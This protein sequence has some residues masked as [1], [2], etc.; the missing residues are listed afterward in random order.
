VT[1]AAPLKA[2]RPRLD[3]AAVVTAAAD[4]L[5]ESG[6]DSFSM[7][8][9]GERL[10]VTAMALYRHVADRDD[11]EQALVEQV[12]SDFRG[13]SQP[14]ADWQD[15]LAD[16]MNSLRQCWLAHP[17]VGALLGNRQEIPATFMSVLDQL[18]E[19]LIRAGLPTVL[20]ARE[21]EQTSRTAIGVL[22]QE[23]SAPLPYSGLTDVVITHLPDAAQPRW[24]SIEKTLRRYSN[25]DLFDDIIDSTVLRLRKAL[26]CAT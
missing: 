6:I 23:V 15:A 12:F 17:W 25:D 10:G 22:L 14:A 16:W 13:G 26:R 18:A 7:S 9:L 2:N 1:R 21:L 11:L 4:L 8:R 5:D 3:R 24:H 19:I 20:V